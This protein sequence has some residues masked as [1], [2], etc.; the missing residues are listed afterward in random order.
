MDRLHSFASLDEVT[1]AFLNGSQDNALGIAQVS[2]TWVGGRRPTL[3]ASGNANAVIG[4]TP[5]LILGTSTVLPASAG[6]TINTGGAMT[7]A[8]WYYVYAN[9]T[10]GAIG[11]ELS[12]TAPDGNLQF[13]TGNTAKV[14]VGALYANSTTTFVPVN[15]V[16]GVYR[17]RV[18]GSGTAATPNPFVTSGAFAGVTPLA[19]PHAQSALKMRVVYTGVTGSNCDC[20]V[21]AVGDTG[22]GLTVAHALNA[23]DFI[24]TNDFEFPLFEA[25]VTAATSAVFYTLGFAEP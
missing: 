15:M 13:M 23:G 24:A 9:N 14:Y 7:S 12:T 4:S 2:G 3:F 6:A 21:R 10:G 11:F 8:T 17:Y 22:G 18:P 19:P 5:G 25:K 1:S 20:L 16:N